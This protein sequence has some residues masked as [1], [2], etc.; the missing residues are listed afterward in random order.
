[1]RG[2]QLGFLVAALLGVAACGEPSSGEGTGGSG[3]T[4]DEH[5]VDQCTNDADQAI[6]DSGTDVTAIANGCADFPG[7]CDPQYAAV[8]GSAGKSESAREA[9]GDCVAQCISGES[10]LSSGCA[11]CYGMITA[12]GAAT[13]FEICAPAPASQECADC[14]VENCGEPFEA[15]VGS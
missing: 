6:Y 3:G 10:G 13:C 9:L 4:G 14:A 12:C 8:I 5:P 7:V 15:C 11:G 1:M 2:I